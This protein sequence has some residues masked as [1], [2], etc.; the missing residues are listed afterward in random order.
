MELLQVAL[1][2]SDLDRTARFY[3]QLL[4]VPPTGRF[5]P[6]GLLFFRLGDSRLLF[7]ERAPAALVYVRVP[8]LEEALRRLPDDAE[9]V[10][11]P[12]RIFTHPDDAIGPAGADEWHAALRD[13]DGNL[14]VLVELVP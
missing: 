8:D 10:G 3:E 7:E 1:R 12:Q 13:P 14:V 2:A 6:P 9:R 4:G 11:T 5:D